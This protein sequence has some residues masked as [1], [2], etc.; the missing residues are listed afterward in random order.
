MVMAV[1]ISD[2]VLTWPW[3]VAGFVLAALLFW[4]GTW[5]LRDEE[6]PRIAI[7]TAA[8]FISSLIHIRMPMTSIHLLLS[9]L[10]GVVLGPRAVL[11]IAVGLVLQLF[12]IEHGGRWT[13]G[14]NTCVMAIPALLSWIAFRTLHRMSWTRHPVARALLVGFGAA[15]LFL[16]G[17]YSGILIWLTPLTHLDADTFAQANAWMLNPWVLVSAVVFAAIAVIVEIRLE[18][19]PEFPLGFLIGAMSVLVTA[20]L[21]CV[22]LI[23]GGETNWPLAPLFLVI[24]HLPFAVVEGVILGVI[25]GFLAQVKPELLGIKPASA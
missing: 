18:N 20:G 13:L 21:N 9:G 2:G 14:I 10:V 25:V 11:A 24:A 7:L 5:R 8:F 19:T 22:V 4:A 12:L 3:L 6:I 15:I 16:S 1:H 17:V 23:L